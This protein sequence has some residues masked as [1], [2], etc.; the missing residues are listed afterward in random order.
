MNKNEICTAINDRK[1]LSFDYE[2][3]NRVVE[4]FTL[5]KTGKDND[6]LSAYQVSGEAHRSTVPCWGLFNLNKI[7]NLEV[8]SENFSANR[9]KYRRDDSRMHNIYCQI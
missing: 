7:S 4:P 1:L 5:G 3:L 6:V 8:L 2:N 9:E